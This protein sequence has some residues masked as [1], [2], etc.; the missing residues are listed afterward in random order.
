MT[1]IIAQ[2]KSRESGG[3]FRYEIK[4]I[5]AF[6]IEIIFMCKFVSFYITIY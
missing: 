2:R 3:F 5:I 1:Y 6:N 4:K